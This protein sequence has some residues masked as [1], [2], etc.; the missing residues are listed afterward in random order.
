MEKEKLTTKQ[1]RWF[2]EHL[3]VS[4]MT[5]L[6]LFSYIED[7]VISEYATEVK[8]EMLEKIVEIGRRNN[9]AE[10]KDGQLV[11]IFFDFNKIGKEIYLWARKE[12]E[13]LTLLQ[14]KV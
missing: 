3:N 10:Y 9:V 7:E 8:R 4:K 1:K 6:A 5:T 11:D 13:K 2:V 12:Q 14:E